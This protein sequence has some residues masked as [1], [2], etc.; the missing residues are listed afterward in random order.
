VA[1]A[2]ANVLTQGDKHKYASYEL[3]GSSHVSIL[4]IAAIFEKLSGVKLE[5]IYIE[6][7]NLFDD[8]SP[9][10][11]FSNAGN[12]SYARAGVLAIRDAYNEYGFAAN[13]N[14]LEWLLGRESTTMEQYIQ[15]ELERVGHPV[16]K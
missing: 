10:K 5:T 16:N 13:K 8:D 2:A 15:R 12:D 9:F 4:D 3:C 1:E 6:R 7:E 14:V 11:N